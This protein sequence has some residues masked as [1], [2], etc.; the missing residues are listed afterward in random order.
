MPKDN[1]KEAL[2]AFKKNG[3]SVRLATLEE[4][5]TEARKAKHEPY[6]WDGKRARDVKDNFKKECFA[7]FSTRGG[8]WGFYSARKLI[9]LARIMFRHER[10]DSYY[11]PQERRK[12][13]HVLSNKN[14]RHRQ[15]NAF[16]AELSKKDIDESE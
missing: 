8:H 3:Y 13:W 4:K 9:H 11:A 16:R 1:L 7:V 2:A 5:R 10:G 6:Q 15:N 14:V 12:G